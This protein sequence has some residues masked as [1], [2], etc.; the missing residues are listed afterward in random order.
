MKGHFRKRNRKGNSWTVWFDLPPGPDLKRRQKSLTV[1]GTRKDA[2]R[3]FARRRHEMEQGTYVD[4][5]KATLGQYLEHWLDMIAHDVTARTLQA[6]RGHVELHIVSTIGNVK[7][8]DLRPAHID[9]AKRAW[10]TGERKDKKAG[11]LSPH[12]VKHVFSTL[13]TALNKAKRQRIIAVNPCESVDPPRWERQEMTGSLDKERAVQ[14]LSV[15]EQSEIGAAVVTDM[16]SGLRRGELLALRWGDLD[17]DAGRLAVNRALEHIGNQVRFKEPKTKQSR[18]R[19]SLPAFVVQRLRK[20]RVEQAERFLSLGLG[21]PRA[22]TLVFERL[23]KAY[24]P[25]TFGSIFARLVRRANLGK[26]RLHDLRH[27][28]ASMS[29]EAGVDMKT[30]S[31]ALGHSSIST[32]ADIYAHVTPALMRSAADRLEDTLG[33]AIAKDRR[34]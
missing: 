16:G 3:E 31:N 21:R 27:T 14:L 33:R 5:R 29:L 4:N 1:K 18:R 8:G 15:F 2:E 13:F 17:L 26:V 12:T 11:S 10:I 30:V 19:I 25:A 20:H 28:F 9:A 32:T 22:D 23:G 24:N 7:L 6:Y 34:A